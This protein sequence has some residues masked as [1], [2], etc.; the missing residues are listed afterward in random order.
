MNIESISPK[1]Y[2]KSILPGISF[3]VEIK[4]MKYQEAIISVNGWV[5]TDDKNMI[6]SLNEDIPEGPK[7]SEIQAEGSRFDNNF[8][9][10]LYKTT[11]VA[12]LNKRALNHIETRRIKDKKRD[13]KLTLNLKVKNIE[14]RTVIC[15]LHEVDPRNMGLRLINIPKLEKSEGK[16]L[17]YAYDPDFSTSRVD[18]WILSGN[19]GPT[20]LAVK[21][22]VLKKEVKISSSDWIHD[23]APKL[24]L[25]EYFIVEIPKGKKIIEEAWGYIEKAEECYRQWD[26]KG[27]Y[28]NCREAGGLLDQIVKTKFGKESFVYKEK[29]KRSYERFNHFASLNLHI[30]EI[31]KSY[32]PE[33]LSIGKADTE[34][35]LIVTKALV[36][37][38]EELLQMER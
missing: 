26:T 30:E 16:L 5:E 15:H 20:F 37:Y 35:I 18:Q 23:F 7:A 33:E 24:E 21:E 29:W 28:A 1:P 11:V 6:A 27:V 19:G 14:S 22:D 8:K 13:V 9:E 17:A 38:A 31:K 34:H 32:S 25:G 10:N 2:E 4:Y 3:E 36:K 12:L